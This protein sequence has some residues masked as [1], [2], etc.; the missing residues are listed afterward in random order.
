[1]VEQMFFGADDV[2]QVTRRG[3]MCSNMSIGMDHE[4]DEVDIACGDIFFDEIPTRNS[5]STSNKSGSQEDSD[6]AMD[7]VATDEGYEDSGS[8]DD[9]VPDTSTRVR[10]RKV[11]PAFNNRS[12]K[13]AERS[14]LR[15]QYDKGDHFILEEDNT[16][17]I[18]ST[19]TRDPITFERRKVN[20]GRGPK[21]ITVELDS[22]DELMITMREKGY[23]DQ[24]IADRLAKDGR[25]NYDRK[26][27]S[28]RINRIRLVQAKHVDMMLGEGYKEWEYEDDQLL[29]EAY[30]RAD[31]E[32]SYEIERARAWR[33]RKVSEFMRRL[34]KDAIF[35]ETAVRER[36]TDLINGTASIPSELDDNPIARRMEIESYREQREVVREAERKQKE[37][38]AADLKHVREETRMRQAIRFEESARAH[39]EKAQKQALKSVQRAAQYQMKAE[40]AKQHAEARIRATEQARKDRADRLA[41]KKD[42]I[43]RQNPNAPL[44]MDTLA[45]VAENMAGAAEDPRVCLT[46]EQLKAIC[47]Q[48]GLTT[49]GRSSEEYLNRLQDADDLLT[50]NQL[51]SMCRLKGLNH[52]G[53]KPILKYQLAAA[54]AKI[55]SASA[56][57]ASEA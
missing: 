30:A 45:S 47:A 10:S 51:K 18:K 25:A 16:T 4:Q 28:S 11:Q 29:I 6:D 40:R 53:T 1:M 2:E 41:A 26:S 49:D 7:D 48:R 3:S 12:T 32:V 21:R 54:E 42:E 36:Y 52:S 37:K 43:H 46:M 35:S 33:W 56:E 34:N 9:Y 24:Q 13:A 27:I 44:S 50:W 55:F 22:D 14:A 38:D 23:N 39:E 31:I 19:P 5:N 15:A 20:N 17:L 57:V 8:D